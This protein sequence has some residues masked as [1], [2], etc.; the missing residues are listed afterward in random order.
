M[1][2]KV[3][4]WFGIERGFSEEVLALLVLC[5]LG[6]GGYRGLE[7]GELLGRPG[8]RTSLV[9]S[10]YEV[11]NG[12]FVY[13]H[14]KENPLDAD[15]N[16][17]IAFLDTQFHQPCRFCPLA[18]A[19]DQVL[20][21]YHKPSLTMQSTNMPPTNFKRPS[22]HIDHHRQLLLLIAQ[23][24]TGRCNGQIQTTPLI[25]L[26]LL[27]TRQEPSNGFYLVVLFWCGTS[28]AK[29]VVSNEFID[30]VTTDLFQRI[31]EQL[32]LLRHGL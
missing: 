14:G 17:G 31:L 15:N 32:L 26:P 1:K 25:E 11:S 8:S 30:N 27:F 18:S 5:W 9:D 16:H 7:G 12:G 3:R 19:I 23:G 21:T 28:R 13:M 6:W 22:V 20:F 29:H 2:A 10:W 24:I 4:S